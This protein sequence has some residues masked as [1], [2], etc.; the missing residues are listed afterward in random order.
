MV[1]IELGLNAVKV[2]RKI[3]IVFQ[4]NHPRSEIIINKII[5]PRKFG[6]IDWPR[7]FVGDFK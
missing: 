4:A 3:D 7:N 5:L 6:S 1:Y 2:I